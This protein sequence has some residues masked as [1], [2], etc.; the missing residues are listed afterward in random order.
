[1]ENSL[2]MR[3]IPHEVELGGKQYTILFDMRAYA[4][5]EQVYYLQYGRRCNCGE[6]ILDMLNGLTSALMAL[7]YG[8]LKSGGAKMDY[9]TFAQDILTREDASNLFD[10]VERAMIDSMGLNDKDAAIDGDEKN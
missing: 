7:T 9:K 6:I 2:N 4:E 5:A 10:V 3:A 1:M 8:A